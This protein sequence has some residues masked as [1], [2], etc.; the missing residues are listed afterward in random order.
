MGLPRL[1]DYPAVLCR[2]T[3]ST[4]FLPVVDGLR[5]LAILPVVVQHLSERVI[6]IAEAR[7][8]ATPFDYALMEMLPRGRLGV[9]LFFAISGLIISYPFIQAY[10]Q[11]T[12]MPNV[13]AFYLR[14]L[15]R[16]EPPYF[17]VMIAIYLFVQSTGYVPEGT[18]AFSRSDVSMET[19]LLASLGYVHGLLI[20]TNPILNPPAWSLEIEIQ[21]YFIAPLILLAV[22]RLGRRI[23]VLIGML[24]IIAGTISIGNSFEHPFGIDRSFFIT[25]YL[26][27]FVAGMIVNMIVF[28]GLVPKRI[29][30][31]FWD[32]IFVTAAVAL[33]VISQ[34]IS[35]NPSSVLA[36]GL[37]SISF[38]VFILA[39]FN[40]NVF[41][42]LLSRPWIYAIGGMCYTI[43]LIHLPILHVLTGMVMRTTGL[44]S[45]IPGMIISAVVLIPILFV[46]SVLFYLLVE[47]PCMNPS[48]PVNLWQWT[49]KHICQFKPRRN[50]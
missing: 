4:S 45:F 40:G 35:R 20:G 46:A 14:R 28:G 9:E 33:Y 22:L 8:L 30:A 27:F 23:N 47:K 19:S 10:F 18:L 21:F 1:R 31:S 26:Q 13:K 32:I 7:Q 3:S 24:A 2:S 11:R 44:L 41:K 15:T 39:A 42:N 5:F 16:L 50:N 36:D 25:R 17:L 37:Q 34:W 38:V 12:N 48:W 43:Y 29:S 6:R 49:K